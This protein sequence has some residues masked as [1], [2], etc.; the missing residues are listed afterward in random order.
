MDRVPLEIWQYI[1]SLACMD[2]G[3]TGHA[4]SLASHA[5]RWALQ[6]T[7][8]Q[9]VSLQGRQQI[10]QFAAFFKQRT[11]SLRR[12][13]YLHIRSSQNQPHTEREYEAVACILALAGPS[14]RIVTLDLASQYGHPYRSDMSVGLPP[15][16]F[17]SHLTELVLHGARLPPD[18]VLPSLTHLS[19]SRIPL[20]N[21]PR[22][23][24]TPLPRWG[25]VSC[26]MRFPGD[27]VD[28]VQRIARLAPHLTHL[29]VLG[30][31]PVQRNFREDVLDV[32]PGTLRQFQLEMCYE[33]CPPQ[34][35]VKPRSRLEIMKENWAAF[36]VIACERQGLV[37]LGESDGRESRAEWL[38]SVHGDAG[39]WYEN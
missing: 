27:L 3:E 12:I 13:R 29:R 5:F 22:V 6:T 16:S 26:D 7:T 2:S 1:F 38:D 17:P 20:V 18:T 34:L 11:P 24:V 36:A 14:L 15:S 30:Y 21:D 4:L 39:A 37:M 23:A 25:E 9:S 35:K 28:L 19:V 32:L 8:L 33:P 31:S 10:I